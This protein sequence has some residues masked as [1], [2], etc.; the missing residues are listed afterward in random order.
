M[1]RLGEAKRHVPDCLAIRQQVEAPG[2][3]L[4]IELAMAS[5]VGP[6]QPGSADHLAGSKPQRVTLC[7]VV[8]GPRGDWEPPFSPSALGPGWPCWWLAVKQSFSVRPKLNLPPG[9]LFLSGPSQMLSAPSLRPAEPKVSYAP[10]TAPLPSL[11]APA[12]LPRLGGPWQRQ[13]GWGL[14]SFPLCQSSIA[15]WGPRETEIM[16]AN[17][18]CFQEK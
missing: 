9:P 15:P 8:V 6:S 12:P 1:P 7:A 13:P 3:I 14:T 16:K 4:R 17:E 2:S 11:T 10:S 5:E 18:H